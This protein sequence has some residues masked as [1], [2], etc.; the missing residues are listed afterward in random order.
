MHADIIDG[1]H[2]FQKNTSNTHTHTMQANNPLLNR[3]QQNLTIT[4]NAKLVTQA[5]EEGKNS[6]NK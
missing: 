2:M 1:F 6:K 4:K 5:Q 3:K